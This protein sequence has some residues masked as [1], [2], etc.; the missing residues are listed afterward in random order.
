M[1][2]G[3]GK[4]L[5]PVPSHLSTV[6][7]SPLSSMPSQLYGTT[8]GTVSLYVSYRVYDAILPN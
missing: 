4:T 6:L 2:G 3:S 1:S 7:C 5:T 8:R